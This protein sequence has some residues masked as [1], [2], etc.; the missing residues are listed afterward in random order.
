LAVRPGFATAFTLIELLVVIA[1]I[2]VL[3][4]LLL[5]ALSRAKEGGRTAVCKN[6][7]RQWGM[8]TRMYL[9]DFQVYPPQFM[10]DFRGGNYRTWAERLNRYT[11]AK[12]WPDRPISTQTDRASIESCPTYLNFGGWVA[13]R[14]G[15][16]GYNW[17]G[18][19]RKEGQELGLGGDILKASVTEEFEPGQLRLV[20]EAE[21]LCPSDMILIGDAFIIDESW[22]VTSPTP[23]S[24][25]IEGG[26]DLS[27]IVNDYA[28][29]NPLLG[30]PMHST[31][32]P[33]VVAGLR[34]MA[35]RHSGRFNVAF[36]DGHIE[37]LAP[38]PFADPH[39]D[40]VVKRWNRDNLPHR[41]DSPLPWP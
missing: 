34:L 29:L 13:Q 38:K 10:S 37:S 33:P 35:K 2:A 41:K 20:R 24:K 25:F 9:D 22:N 15:S 12:R 6:N 21:V 36:C 8:G 18:Y 4:S 17:R 30:M 3:A 14:N 31:P 26:Y 7:L 16:Y 19:W 40:N 27:V 32:L 11:G 28:L 39:D 1:I 5:P 23:D